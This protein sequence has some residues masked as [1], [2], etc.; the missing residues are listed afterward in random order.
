[1][2]GGKGA[3]PNPIGTHSRDSPLVYYLVSLKIS[4]SL[5]F[6]RVQFL[7]GG[8]TPDPN[9]RSYADVITETRLRN[10]EVCINIYCFDD[11]YLSNYSLIPKSNFL[12]LPPA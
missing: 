6:L 1:M 4:C 5:I 10:E 3:E 8:K 2:A 9:K 7:A 11:L 12:S